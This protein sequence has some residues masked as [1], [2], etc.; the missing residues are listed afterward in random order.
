M[1]P[2]PAQVKLGLFLLWISIPFI[3][4]G[5]ASLINAFVGRKMINGA[6]IY[7]VLAAAV[8]AFGAWRAISNPANTP[9][10]AGELIGHYTF[11]FGIP[12][13][14]AI[15]F[16]IR[17]NKQ[18]AEITARQDLRGLLNPSTRSAKTTDVIESPVIGQGTDSRDGREGLQIA[19]TPSGKPELPPGQPG[20]DKAP[21]AAREPW[22]WQDI[23]GLIF[24]LIVV[25]ALCIGIIGILRNIP[26]TIRF[27]WD[28]FLDILYAVGR[29]LE[30]LV[31]VPEKLTRP[32]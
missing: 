2:D 10:D 7:L 6:L 30:K 17:F 26:D 18:H 8:F 25:I 11:Y 4:M 16:S 19:G 24:G 13:S 20:A 22:T 29:F 15:Y 3:F 1:E 32:P 5:V 23:A 21:T 31:H 14:I 28:P 9:G 12:M 27:L